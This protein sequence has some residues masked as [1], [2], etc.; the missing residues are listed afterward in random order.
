MTKKPERIDLT[1]EELDALPDG[2]PRPPTKLYVDNQAAIASAYNPENH[3]KLKH[4]ERRHFYIREAIEAHRLCVP[5][6]R[7]DANLADFFTKPLLRVIFEV[8]REM[9]GMKMV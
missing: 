1:E 5:F 8:L 7:S 9:L 3:G 4:V 6:V 2:S